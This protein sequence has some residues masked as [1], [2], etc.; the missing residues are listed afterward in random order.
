MLALFPYSALRGGFDYDYTVVVNI[1]V[2]ASAV[3]APAPQPAPKPTPTAD[4]APSGGTQ[5]TVLQWNIHHG[6]GT[7]GKYDLNRFATWMGTWNPDV[8]TI[9]EAEK[10][11][12]WGNEDQP[13]RF[14]ALLEQKT[15]VTWYAHF[16]QEF[17]DWTSNGKGNLILSRYPFVSTGREVLDWD[18]TM[19]IAVITV[20]GRNISLISTHLDPDSQTRRESQARQVITLA[21]SW[22]TPRLVTGDFNAWP[23]QSSIAVMT[24]AYT[25]TWA[26]AEASGTASSFSGNSPFGATKNGRIDYVFSTPGA[27]A[28]TLKQVRV[29]DT[30]DSSGVM[31]SDHRP[32]LATFDVR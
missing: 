15:G 11:T 20:N 14:K 2:S 4:P 31:P 29:P 16:A 6:V 22:S 13:A 32:V 21:S 27:T 23:D 7:D 25:D 3:P 12:S 8:V 10:F 24:G 30:R 28:L 26:R 19:A 17:G 18:R 9:N 5:L 1:T